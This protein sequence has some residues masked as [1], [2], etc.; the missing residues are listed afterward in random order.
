MKQLFSS[1]L[2]GMTLVLAGCGGG[3]GDNASVTTPAVP[4]TIT[5]QKSD[6][7]VGTGAEA[8]VGSNV[9]VHYTGYLY[10]ASKTS[11]K[12]TTFDSSV[13]RSPFEFKVGAGGVIK[14]FDEGVKG[15]K[16]GGKRT[17][18]IPA[19]MGYGA[20]VNGSIPANSNLVFDIE[21]VSVK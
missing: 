9:A 11:F 7:V 18:L 5:L 10:D 14:G 3:G 21:L 8:V 6:T 12:G 2:F 4:D 16:V 13:G 15:M 1:C 19:S 20:T 17:V